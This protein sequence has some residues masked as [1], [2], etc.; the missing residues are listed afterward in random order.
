MIAMW[1]I[2]SYLHLRPALSLPRQAK[3]R[4]KAGTGR[5]GWFLVTIHVSFGV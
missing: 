3:N 5:T 2:R 1:E 4:E